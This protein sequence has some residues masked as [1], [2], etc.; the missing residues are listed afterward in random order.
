MDNEELAIGIDLGTTYSCVAV[1]RDGNVEIIP[2]EF[3]ENVTPSVV[4]F[5]DNGILV[6][7]QALNQIIKN[8]KKTI[9]SI[10]RLIGRKYYE[11]EVQ[12]DIKSNFWSF[13]IVEEKSNNTPIVKIE[14]EKNNFSMYYYPEQISRYI[15]EKLVQNARN[16]L[17]RP[18]RKAVITVPAYFQD[19]QRKATELAANLAG[20]EVLRI[21]NEP[22]AASLAYGLNK[23]LPKKITNN[24]ILYLNK[25]KNQN[26]NEKKINYR[27]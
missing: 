13:D 4:T 20:L 8:P 7:E 9:Y 17:N 2:N 24:P 16:Y 3:D 21:I 23:K 27:I 26:I 1:M 5:I 22:T 10:K 18:I 19:A 6:G 25:E 11:K 14:D 15:L 12:K